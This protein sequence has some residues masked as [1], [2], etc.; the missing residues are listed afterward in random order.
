MLEAFDVVKDKNHTAAGRKGG[1]SPLEGHAVDRACQL[2]V[3]AAEVA[4]WR[5]LFRGVDGLFQRDKVEAL[6]AQVHEDQVD[7]EA[8]QPGGE[9]GFAAEASDLAEEVE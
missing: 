2:G 6:L 9:G 7:C 1:D 8:M 5:I 4:L 3:S